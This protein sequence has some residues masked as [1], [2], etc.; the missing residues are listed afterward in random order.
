MRHKGGHWL[1][2]DEYIV[3]TESG[4]E[5]PLKKFKSVKAFQ[6]GLKA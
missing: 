3:H 4:E 2:H 6:V 5:I 1:V